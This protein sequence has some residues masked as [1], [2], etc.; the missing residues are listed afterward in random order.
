MSQHMPDMNVGIGAT[1]G[2][3]IAGYKAII[4]ADVNVDI[5][6]DF[7]VMHPLVGRS[8]KAIAFWRDAAKPFE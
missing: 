5:D 6:C 4:P 1:V 2:C 7:C 3:V 8:I